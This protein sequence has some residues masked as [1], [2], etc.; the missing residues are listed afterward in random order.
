LLQAF[1]PVTFHRVLLTFVATLNVSGGVS[2]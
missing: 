1:L 2:A